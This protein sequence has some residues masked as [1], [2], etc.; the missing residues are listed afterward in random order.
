[1]CNKK[2]CP[3]DFKSEAVLFAALAIQFGFIFWNGIRVFQQFVTACV[4]Q[5]FGFPSA[6]WV[7]NGQARAMIFFIDTFISVMSSPCKCPSAR[8]FIIA[9]LWKQSYNHL[10]EK[11]KHLSFSPK[12]VSFSAVFLIVAQLYNYH[13]MSVNQNKH[14]KMTGYLQCSSF[15]VS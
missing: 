1:M 5:F 14:L 7:Y 2:W 11:I 15:S 10:L 3:L 12:C 8:I 4:E 6:I 9:F 13:P